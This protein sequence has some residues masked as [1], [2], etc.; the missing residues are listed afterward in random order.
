VLTESLEVG[1]DAGGLRFGA[2]RKGAGRVVLVAV[3]GDGP[4]ANRRVE[5]DGLGSLGV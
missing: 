3:D 2:S 5:S 4:K 1:D